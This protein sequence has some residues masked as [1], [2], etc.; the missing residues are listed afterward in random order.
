MVGDMQVTILISFS[1]RYQTNWDSKQ[2][3][4]YDE[5]KTCFLFAEIGTGHH[6]SNVSLSNSP[7]SHMDHVSTGFGRSGFGRYNVTTI[8][9]LHQFTQIILVDLDR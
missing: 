1:K 7:K 5:S 2:L 6:V 4:V 8:Y 3:G 9:N